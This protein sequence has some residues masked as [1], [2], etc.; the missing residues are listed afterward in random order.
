MQLL[1]KLGGTPGSRFAMR[2]TALEGDDLAAKAAKLRN[3][4]LNEL[5]RRSEAVPKRSTCV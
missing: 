4:A 1:D 2:F 3:L 5:H